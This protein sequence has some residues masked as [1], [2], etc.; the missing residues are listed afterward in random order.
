MT[1]DETM[2]GWRSEK[3]TIGQECGGATRERDDGAT[4]GEDATTSRRDEATRGRRSEKTVRG[5]DSSV[6]AT[7][8]RDGGATVTIT[9]RHHSIKN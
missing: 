9:E 1:R 4:R 5:Q 8:G 6:T 2:I 7:R 3:T